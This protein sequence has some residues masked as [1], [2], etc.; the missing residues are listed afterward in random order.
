MM[1]NRNWAAMKIGILK[2]GDTPAEL[3]GKFGSYPDMFERLLDGNGF[4]FATYSVDDDVFPQSSAECDG[5]LITGS[6]HGVYDEFA[7]IGK[8]EEF[9]RLA[10]SGNVP[11]AGICF[12]HQIMAQALGG[13]AEKFAGGWSI[14]Q[15]HY[16]LAKGGEVTLNAMHQDQV[17]VCPPDAETI[18]S[19]EFCKFAGL[20]YGDFGIS[21]QA[22]PEYSDIFERELIK[23]RSGTVV[24]A[25]LVETA[26][27]SFD[28]END[29]FLIADQIADFFRAAFQHKAA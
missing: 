20:A 4:S 23:L 6:R 12:G 11:I 8:L 3:I 21:F 29:N 27:A 19:S 2:T 13:R 7:W 9:I 15:Q 18:A 24:P 1:H 5:W 16:N 22:H 10:W 28:Q 25:E 17:T 26:L 14:G